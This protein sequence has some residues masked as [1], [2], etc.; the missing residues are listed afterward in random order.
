MVWAVAYAL[1]RVRLSR[2]QIPASAR[3]A[4][5]VACRLAAGIAVGR[6]SQYLAEG[7]LVVE[8]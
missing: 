5:I 4:S 2:A 1:D 3:V 8:G 6:G 7:G